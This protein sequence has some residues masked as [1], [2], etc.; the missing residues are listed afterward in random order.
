MGTRGPSWPHPHAH[1]RRR[2]RYAM[3]IS[4]S[5]RLSTT[6][7]RHPALVA[8]TMARG[9]LGVCCLCRRHVAPRLAP[10]LDSAPGGANSGTILPGGSSGFV[11]D[12]RGRPGATGS[13]QA[14]PVSLVASWAA[15]LRESGLCSYRKSFKAPELST[16][17]TG[18]F[19]PSQTSLCRAA[20]SDV[21]A[22]SLACPVSHL[23]RR[24]VAVQQQ[25][26]C[27]AKRERDK[28]FAV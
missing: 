11:V 1:L 4:T 9:W 17:R 18:L 16:R 2:Y 28:V 6:S 21:R 22:H 19:G 10:C 14:A 12:S 13:R 25:L 5:P 8:A 3:L 27:R 7:R 20:L 15:S 23:T 26:R 24:W